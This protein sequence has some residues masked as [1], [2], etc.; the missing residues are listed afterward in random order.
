MLPPVVTRF[1][2][3]D[4]AKKACLAKEL[5][6]RL[7][8]SGIQHDTLHRNLSKALDANYNRSLT[9]TEKVLKHLLLQGQRNLPKIEN[10]SNVAC[11]LD[12]YPPDLARFQNTICMQEKLMTPII[13]KLWRTAEIDEEYA[14]HCFFDSAANVFVYNESGNNANVDEVEMLLAHDARVQ[15]HRYKTV[16]ANVESILDQL[17]CAFTCLQLS[18]HQNDEPGKRWEEFVN[19]LQKHNSHPTYDNPFQIGLN[20]A[21]LFDKA[22]NCT[23]SDIDLK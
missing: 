10:S 7:N 12:F 21:L 2:I 19:D 13:K 6:R 20:S 15:N 9:D 22:S 8:E 16:T 3:T 23:L 4:H 5:Q 14:D 11:Y 18:D 17:A 1:M